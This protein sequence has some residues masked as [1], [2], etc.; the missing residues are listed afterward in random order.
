[1][2]KDQKA[3]QIAICH[4]IIN[5]ASQLK[6]SSTRLLI[7]SRAADLLIHLRAQDDSDSLK[8]F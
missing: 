5:L 6:D 8:I 1:M 2:N 4:E 3:E 7:T